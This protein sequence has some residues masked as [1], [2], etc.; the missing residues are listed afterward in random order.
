MEDKAEA[1]KMSVH[2]GHNMMRIRKAKGI[3]Q[4]WMAEVMELS[5]QAIS[6]LENQRT[7][8]KERLMQIAGILEISVEVLANMEEDPAVGMA[9]ENHDFQKSNEDVSIQT[10]VMNVDDF[11]VTDEG[12]LT[13]L[14]ERNNE[15]Y[16]RLIQ[17]NVR[18]A[19]L[20]EEL[21]QQRD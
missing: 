4:S 21:K 9:V 2:Q 17:A 11:N 7:I 1:T 6:M 19:Q 13:K 5:Q 14:E 10:A 3:K 18:I 12:I 8:S 20:E 15:L 16:E